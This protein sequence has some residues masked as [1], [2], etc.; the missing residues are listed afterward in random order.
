M[1][2]CPDGRLSRDLLVGYFLGGVEPRREWKV[3][4]ELEKMGRG[5]ANGRP[6]PYDGD[7]PTVRKVLEFYL[8]RRGGEPIREAGQIIG[9]RAPWGTITLEPAGQLEWSSLPRHSLAELEQEFD[10]HLSVLGD[11]ASAL[12]IKWLDVAVDPVHAVAD[13]PWMPKARYAIMREYFRKRG[14]LAHRMMTQ[15]AAIQCAFDYADH[16]DWTRKFR[17]AAILAPVATAM[18]ANSA[19]VDGEESGYRSFRQA[20]WR[21]TDDDRCGLPW[22]VFEEG[23]GIERWV[24]WLL[25]VPLLFRRK[26]DGLLPPDG[27]TFRQLLDGP[28]GSSLDM[29]DWASHCSGIFTE[30]RCYTYLEVRSADLQP[31]ERAFAVPTFWAA[32][33]YDDDAIDAALDT[34][35]NLDHASW[36]SAMDSAAKH[37]LDGTAGRFGLRELAARSLAAAIR[38][39]QRGIPCAGDHT[40]SGHLERLASHLHLDLDV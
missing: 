5:I 31:D 15:T 40:P 33:L 38:G 30:V 21:Q 39:L 8:E 35:G 10:V 18:F 28:E 26:G 32:T 1:T 29:E 16:E 24:D 11:A 13:M 37:G 17:T 22:V 2:R 19:R 34:G 27:S 3:G 36:R 4:M 14:R 9:L 7:G 12:G 6:I 25:D 20:I 23:F